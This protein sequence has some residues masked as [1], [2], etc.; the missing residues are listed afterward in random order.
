MTQEELN[1]L[2]HKLVAGA[3]KELREVID[4]TVV[5]EPEVIPYLKGRKAAYNHVIRLI[6][7]I[8]SSQQG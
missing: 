6:K 4:D 7:G 3:D 2:L 5:D 8:D 1:T